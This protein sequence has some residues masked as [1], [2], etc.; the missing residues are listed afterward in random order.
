MR[1]KI[2]NKLVLDVAIKDADGVLITDLA[3]A[4]A[5]KFM[6]KENWNDLDAAA[7]VSK[8]LSNGIVVDTPST[9]YI[10]VTILSTDT[11]GIATATPGDKYC[12][13]QIEYSASNKIEVDL[14]DG[15]TETNLIELIEDVI[16]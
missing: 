2:G 3:T 1:L 11:S 8:S 14:L 9:G 15:S 6:I 16:R 10:R 13:L 4:T 5:V 12:A 7:I